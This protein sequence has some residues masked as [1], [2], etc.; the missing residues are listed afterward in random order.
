MI[1]RQKRFVLREREGQFIDLPQLSCTESV[2]PKPKNKLAPPCYPFYESYYSR[3]ESFAAA[4]ITIFSTVAGASHNLA[5]SG[6]FYSG[7]RDLTICYY[8]GLALCNWSDACIRSYSGNGCKS[9]ATREHL[10][11][12][13]ECPIAAT[14]L[15]S[16]R[17][18]E[19][20]AV[21][22]RTSPAFRI[23]GD[24]ATIAANLSTVTHGL[25]GRFQ[26]MSTNLKREFDDYDK[27]LRVFRNCR[28]SVAIMID[29][30]YA[31]VEKARCLI[32][33][34]TYDDESVVVATTETMTRL[35]ETTESFESAIDEHHHRRRRTSSSPPTSS[36]SSSYDND[37]RQQRCVVCL[38]KD[39]DV[40][41]LPCRHLATCYEC[42][43]RLKKCP[44]CRAVIWLTISVRW[45]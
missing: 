18:K 14:V 4:A 25:F 24:D 44:V 15:S 40:L 45:C 8:C 42:C 2:A 27:F 1:R 3:R 21:A 34:M 31:S 38:S 28:T 32:E 17:K 5:I 35:R 13:K 41:T 7:I 33:A 19:E 36:S 23:A 26:D 20:Y 11:W 43:D 12:S 22:P 30:M 29:N 37:G 9:P 6:F 16:S 39:R 10:F